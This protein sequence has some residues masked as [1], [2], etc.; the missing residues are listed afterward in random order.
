[1]I[2]RQWV[3]EAS[4]SLEPV[5]MEPAQAWLE[6]ELIAAKALGVER[7]WLLAH[8]ETVLT[9]MQEAAMSDLLKRRQAHEPMAYVLGKVDFAGRSFAVDLRVLI[10]RVETEE[11]V[12][13]AKTFSLDAALGAKPVIWDVGTGSG[14]LAVTLALETSCPTMASDVSQTALDVAKANADRLIQDPFQK[15]LFLEDSL[16][17]SAVKQVLATLQPTGLIVCANLPYLPWSDQQALDRSVTRF[18]PAQALFADEEGLALNRMLLQQL[19]TLS[20]PWAAILEFDPPQAETLQTIAQAILPGRR[21]SVQQ[22]G[23][24]RARFLVI[25][26]RV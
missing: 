10:P 19:A 24:G 8:G 16:L 11:M 25:P 23:C 6:T 9:P 18:E 3:A 13:I 5:C 12:G 15:P 21:V 26:P 4:K 2:L 7:A 14:A 22:D 20:M 17:G 1:M